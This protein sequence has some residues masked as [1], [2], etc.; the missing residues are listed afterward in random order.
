MRS[1]TFVLLFTLS[2]V[3]F[4]AEGVT[5]CWEITGNDN[6]ISKVDDFWNIKNSV[7]EES[8]LLV[9]VGGQEEAIP[10]NT[11]QI[12]ELRP[13]KKSR[14]KLFRGNTTKGIITFTD[15]SEREFVS[16]LNLISRA[17]D[18]K[19]DVQFTTIQ[20]I[21][22]CPGATIAVEKPA[23]QKNNAVIAETNTQTAFN[24]D[25]DVIKMVNGDILNGTILTK[26]L[27]WKASFGIISVHKDQIRQMTLIRENS[28]DGLLESI[29]R[30]RINGL[31]E[32][33]K[34]KMKLSIGQ[35]IEVDT[36]SIKTIHF[37]K[38][39]R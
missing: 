11:I 29:S 36:D 10:V 17:G 32:T 4:P 26:E 28:P 22:K 8:I 1:I 25:A 27:L 5:A 24:P 23:L 9:R 30:D 18:K 33:N 21:R 12:I 19:I 2:S 39:V 20:S 35:T 3:T 31:L 38:P 37:G 15:G 7:T 13:I 14:L 16:D 34:I 6:K